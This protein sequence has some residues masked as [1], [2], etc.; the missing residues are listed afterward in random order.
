MITKERALDLVE[1]IETDRLR[2]ATAAE[3]FRRQSKTDKAF[4]ALGIAEGLGSAA[5]YIRAALAEA[6]SE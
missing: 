2:A 3:T 1:R 5:S 6:A 4:R